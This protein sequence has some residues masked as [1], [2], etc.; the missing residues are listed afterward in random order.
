MNVLIDNRESTHNMNVEGL[1]FN[2]KDQPDFFKVLNNRVNLYFKEKGISKKANLEMVIKTI[3]ML[4]LYFVPLCFLL[5]GVITSFWT[6]MLMWSIMGLGMAGIGLSVM[7]DANH[8]SYSKNEFVNKMVG[9]VI[10]FMGAFHATWKI[11]HNVLHHSFTNIHGFDEDNDNEVMRFSPKRGMKWIF[12]YQ[13]YYAPFLYC[14][15][16]LNRFLVKDFQQLFSFHK[17]GLLEG[18]GL[19]FTSALLQILFHKIWY[20]VLT[21]VLPTLILPFSFGQIILGFLVMH[22]ICG[23]IL[24]LI[25]Q[26]AHILEETDFFVPGENGRMENNWA[27]HQ[28]RTTANFANTSSVFSW[29]VGGLNFQIEHHLFPNIC[30][31]HYKDISKIVKRTAQ[32]FDLPYHQHTTFWGALRSHFLYLNQLGKGEGLQENKAI[33][34]AA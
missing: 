6:M 21:I 11:Q 7:H 10:N 18:E 5:F 34:N 25:F 29:L 4:S 3:F 9:F 17:K 16:S 14:L 24:A 8:G 26:S 1:K 32:E 27:I 12:K 23:L 31:V 13:A 15:M 28:L 22:F 33:Q 2:K 19:S 30:H 20:V